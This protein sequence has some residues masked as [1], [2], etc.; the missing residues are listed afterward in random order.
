MS[1]AYSHRRFIRSICA[2]SRKLLIDF[3]NTLLYHHG[4]TLCLSLLAMQMEPPSFTPASSD[5]GRRHFVAYNPYGSQ[6]STLKASSS[7]GRAS[8]AVAV[9]PDGPYGKLMEVSNISRSS[10]CSTDRWNTGDAS[11]PVVQAREK[12]HNRTGWMQA[13]A[14]LNVRDLYPPELSRLV[15]RQV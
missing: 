13:P 10:P 12:D 14:L 1:F 8:S 2:R 7:S 11:C 4:V 5:G 9:T 15:V 6:S 3:F